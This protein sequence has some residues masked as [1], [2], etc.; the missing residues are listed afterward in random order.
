[1]S[2]NKI[3][4]TKKK[5]KQIFKQQV[6]KEKIPDEC[7]LSTSFETNQEKTEKSFLSETLNHVKSYFK[8]KPTSQKCLDYHEALLVDVK[9]A[10]FIEAYIN[11]F[12]MFI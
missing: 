6:L 12:F 2:F 7:F 3:D 9:Q 4:I 1:M 11:N 10:N 8:D 5:R